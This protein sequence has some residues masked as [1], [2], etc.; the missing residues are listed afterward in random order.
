VVFIC[1]SIVPIL[2]I[3]HS[4]FQTKYWFWNQIWTII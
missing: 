4:S 3:F 2:C 1:W